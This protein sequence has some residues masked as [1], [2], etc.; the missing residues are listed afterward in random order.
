MQV[1]A[2]KRAAAESS[3]EIAVLQNDLMAER[4]RHLE[5]L[6]DLNVTKERH[7]EAERCDFDIHLFVIYG[8]LCTSRFVTIA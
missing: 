8:L 1:A 3:Q 6:R 7:N 4:E 5:T 2:Y